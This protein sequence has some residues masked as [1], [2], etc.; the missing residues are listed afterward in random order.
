MS[1]GEQFNDRIFTCL[2]FTIGE[3][4]KNANSL[5]LGKYVDPPLSALAGVLQDYHV[6]DTADKQHKIFLFTGDML[7]HKE[8]NFNTIKGL[9]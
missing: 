7:R 3:I 1:Y 8:N 9:E 4:F 5:Y 6:K 2:P